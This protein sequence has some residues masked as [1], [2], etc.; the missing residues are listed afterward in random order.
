MLYYIVYFTLY[1]AASILAPAF[2]A[3]SMLPPE[4]LDSSQQCGHWLTCIICMFNSVE[5]YSMH[6][7]DHFTHV[8]VYSY[9]IF[10]YK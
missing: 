3:A 4:P 1:I 6:A 9:F 2:L 7:I 8:N 10:I 5:I